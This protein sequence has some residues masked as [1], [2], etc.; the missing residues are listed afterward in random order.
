MAIQ[1]QIKDGAVVLSLIETAGFAQ[2]G[3]A[4]DAI[5]NDPA[6]VLRMPLLF[7]LRGEPRKAG[8][9]HVGLRLELLRQMRMRFGSRWALVVDSLPARAGFRQMASALREHGGLDVELFCDWQNAILWSREKPPPETFEFR[10][11]VGTDEAGTFAWL[12]R[13]GEQL[14]PGVSWRLVG[15]TDDED[16]ALGLLKIAGEESRAA[17]GR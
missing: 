17:K 2:L 12:C 14:E 3:S 9:E 8:Y 1:Y 13:G 15:A 6:W 10:V 5:A 4:L 11:Y 7:D 16:T